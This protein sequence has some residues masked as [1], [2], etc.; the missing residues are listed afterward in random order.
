ML[1]DAKV[2]ALVASPP[3]SRQEIA[4]GAVKGLSLRVGPRA[5][6]TWTLRYT[7]SGKGGVT[8]RG[9]R[10]ASRRFYRISLG[11]FPTLSI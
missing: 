4:D 6:P 10:L 5:S 11:D 1:T 3:A 8:A 7:I 9:K 2:R